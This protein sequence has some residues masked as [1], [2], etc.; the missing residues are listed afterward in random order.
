M[1]KF[2][3]TRATRL[4]V[5]RGPA[6][7]LLTLTKKYTLGVEL[8]DPCSAKD[9]LFRA[10]DEIVSVLLRYSEFQPGPVPMWYLSIVHLYLCLCFFTLVSLV[11]SRIRP[12]AYFQIILVV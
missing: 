1:V 6:A 3:S 9:Y 7:L 4:T 5:C 12:T 11:F 10:A 2:P 8:P